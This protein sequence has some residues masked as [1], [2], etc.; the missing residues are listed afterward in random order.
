MHW[1][2]HETHHSTPP[3]RRCGAA[4][5]SLWVG[6]VLLAVHGLAAG[7][8]RLPG[9][10]DRPPETP[11]ALERGAITELPAMPRPI[12]SAGDG[13]AETITTFSAVNFTG[14]SVVSAA[15]LSR[16]ASPYL[17][18]PLTGA[19]LAQLK[20][21]ITR[22]Y[23]ERGYVLMKVTTPPQDISDG[24]LD[25][26]IH[27]ARVG[28]L[29]VVH[30]GRLRGRIATALARRLKSDAVFH[31]GDIES[32]ANDYNDLAGLRAALTL[33]KGIAPGSTDLT[34]TLAAQDED[35]Q[36]FTLDNYG[37]DLTGNW[38][39]AVRLQTNNTLRLGEIL[40]LQLRASDGKLWSAG[41][42]ANT[43]LGLGNLWLNFEYSHS[44]ND[45]GDRLAF[46]DASGTSD[47]ARLTLSSAPIN[48][49]ARK[50]TL[51]SG[52]EMRTHESELANVTESRDHLRQWLV[53]GSYLL[54]QPSWIGYGAV[55]LSK[56][57]DIFGASEWGDA[58]ASRGQGV[59]TAWRLQPLF[60]GLVQL[61]DNS[62]LKAFVSGQIASHG[63]LSSD[64]FALGGYGSVRGFQPAETTGEAGAQYSL[65]YAHRLGVWS[66]T[67][68]TAGVFNDGG[69]VWN[70]ISDSVVDDT[71]H[72]AGFYLEAVYRTQ[73][74]HNTTLRI[75]AAAP[76]G[77]YAS[78][79]VDDYQVL[80]RLT[81]LF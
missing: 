69:R 63:L 75:D 53:E 58:L 7:D 16:A 71:L 48:T 32:L 29:Q 42:D 28:Q 60:Y 57:L 65:E 6:A 72:S 27:E 46:L 11:P 52:L 49:R 2:N 13:T 64:L 17:N 77:D 37:S 9:V 80:V 31:E 47:R 21:D 30:E 25:V 24:I 70:R 51:R 35:I 66:T 40:G 61:S 74:S 59:A 76:L 15:D 23:F 56:G 34:L 55:T 26:V 62:Y 3:H 79:T 50:F 44:E 54:R 33:H 73:T 45:I 8:T 20:F 22:L 38:V 10:I 5:L 1:A 41:V 39:G 18:R 68:W 36:Q 12:P 14:M 4:H 78:Q 19:D 67:Q 43:P 81:Q